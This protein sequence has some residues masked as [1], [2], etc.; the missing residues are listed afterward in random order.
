MHHLAIARTSLDPSNFDGI[1][2][3]DDCSTSSDTSEQR[4]EYEIALSLLAID[5][6]FICNVK[7]SWSGYREYQFCEQYVSRFADMVKAS[8]LPLSMLAALHAHNVVHAKDIINNFSDFPKENRFYTALDIITNYWGDEFGDDSS[9][10]YLLGG[11]ISTYENGMNVSLRSYNIPTKDG[12]ARLI[13]CDAAFKF[14]ARIKGKTL[15]RSIIPSMQGATLEVKDYKFLPAVSEKLWGDSKMLSLAY[16]KWRNNPKVFGSVYDKLLKER[17]NVFKREKASLLDYNTDFWERLY[18]LYPGVRIIPPDDR[19]NRTVYTMAATVDPVLPED[20]SNPL[21]KYLT[22]LAKEKIINFHPLKEVE[23][24]PL[25]MIFAS[26]GRVNDEYTS[27]FAFQFTDCTLH[28]NLA[29]IDNNYLNIANFY[30]RERPTT[31]V[32]TGMKINPP[33]EKNPWWGEKHFSNS[34]NDVWNGYKMAD[35]DE[36]IDEAQEYTSTYLEQTYGIDDIKSVSLGLTREQTEEI[37]KEV[38]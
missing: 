5:L 10:P 24:D 17:K 29:F 1:F 7:K 13:A 20:P 36:I 8:L 28:D 3:N 38:G 9:Y 11:W 34:Y 18:Q 19:I 16:G 25:P 6:G 12:Y 26:Y 31:T 14:P 4:D 23:P 2:L 32:P 15:T 27:T 22:Y 30:F 35:P 37:L 21:S 33:K